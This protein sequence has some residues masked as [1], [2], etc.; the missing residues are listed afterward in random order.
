[1]I[2]IYTKETGARFTYIVEQI[3]TQILGLKYVIE[4]DE[5]K[6]KNHN[7]IIINYSDRAI[8]NSLQI[9][10]HG[11]LSEK[12]ISKKTL[13]VE[14]WDD[15]PVFFETDGDIPF[16]LCAA[17]FYLLSRY[18][19]YFPKEL[20]RHERFRAEE[21]IAYKHDFLQKPVVDCWANKLKEILLKKDASLQFAEPKYRFTPSIDIDNL[22][23]Y[24]HRD[25][26]RTIS[27][28]IYNIAWRNFDQIN[29]RFRTVLGKEKDPFDNIPEIIAL[30]KSYNVEEI[31]FLHFGNFGKYDKRTIDI[32]R[33][34]KALKKTFDRTSS[35]GLHI[36]YQ[37]AF[38]PS[39]IAKEK[40]R[41]ETELGIIVTKNRFH[42]LRFRVPESYQMLLKNG[43]TEDYSMGYSRHIG[44]RASTSFPFHFFDLT[45]NKKTGLLLHPFM[46]MDV[47]LKH[48]LQLTPTE[49]AMQV[50]KNIIDQ[51]KN[52]NGELVTIFHNESLSE[53]RHWAGWSGLYGLI[54]REANSTFI[55][56]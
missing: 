35:L 42:Y 33:E 29:R 12:D 40:K 17:A 32:R 47:A 25:M 11:L 44:F 30:H 46:M 41:M 53:D 5:T 2:V 50:I 1:M 45:E 7:G 27:G 52:V 31:F 56:Y 23:A 6:L 54:L 3:F 43:I 8:D 10:P 14:K 4:T 21:S 16:D 38:S 39:R 37:A 24:K 13:K 36:S 55:S 49:E 18:E 22:F 26:L 19:E 48:G 15:L 28:V 20:D 9:V 34:W 51:V